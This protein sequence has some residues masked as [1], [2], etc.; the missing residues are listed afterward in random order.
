[1]LFRSAVD[2]AGQEVTFNPTSPGRAVPVKGSPLWSAGVTGAGRRSVYVSHASLSGV[3]KRRAKLSFTLAVATNAA[4]LKTITIAMPKGLVL[5][6]SSRDLAKGVLVRA[7]G[8]TL[9][10]IEKVGHGRLAITL[11]APT[12]SA[13]VTISSPAITV[14]ATLAKNVKAGKVKVLSVPVAATDTGHATTSM[15]LML[16]AR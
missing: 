8:R 6:R 14:S 10:S 7:R 3:A 4:G 1:V 13:Q 9:K 16:A 15:T 2:G 11:R 12:S 5:S